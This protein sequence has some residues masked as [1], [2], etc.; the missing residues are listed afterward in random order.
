MKAILLAGVM[1]LATVSSANAFIGDEPDANPDEPVSCFLL[2]NKE[3]VCATVS[4]G[5]TRDEEAVIARIIRGAQKR[6]ERLEAKR[7]ADEEAWRMAHRDQCL[8]PSMMIWCP[9]KK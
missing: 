9:N 5:L 2:P 7:S 8:I 4:D 1:A 3:L 6:T